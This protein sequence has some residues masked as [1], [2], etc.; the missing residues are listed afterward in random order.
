MNGWR[1][2]G[3]AAGLVALLATLT[4]GMNRV[5]LLPWV[6]PPA[7]LASQLGETAPIRRANSP[8]KEYA[9]N[10]KVEKSDSEWQAE[11]TREQFY[12]CRMKGTEAAFSGELWNEHRPGKYFCVACEQPLF[13][14]STKFESGTGWPSFFA[15]VSLQAVATTS[16]RAHGMVRT[17]VTCSRCGAHLGHVFDD[18][19]RPT[20]QRYCMNSAALRFTP[21]EP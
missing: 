2:Q 9:M 7:P 19:P 4:W 11:L 3:M 12:V 13:E 1:I 6:T 18:G 16:D 8:K 21:D 14:A 15:P 5:G 20:G 10:E 17:E